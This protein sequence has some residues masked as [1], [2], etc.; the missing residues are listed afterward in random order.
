[1]S[2]AQR[3][4]ETNPSAT[5]LDRAAMVACI[6]ACF[7]CAQACTAC[8]DACLGEQEKERL[9]RCIRLNVDCADV[10]AMTGK[11]VSRQTASEPALIRAALKFCAQACTLCGDECGKHT[12]EHCRICA[13]ACRRCEA[14]CTTLLQGVP[15]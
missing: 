1:M 15:A 14:A 11:I 4:A 10:C 8:A 6:E 13:E 7:D 2:H 3:M 9:G 5:P 12:M